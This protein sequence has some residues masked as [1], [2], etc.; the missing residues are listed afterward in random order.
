MDTYEKKYK[1][2]LER[3]KGVIEQNPLMEYLKKGIEYIFPELKESEDERIRKAIYNCVKWFGFDSSFFKYVSQ[4]ECL[5]WL[6]KQGEQN[7]AFE[8]KTPEESLGIDSDTYNKIV[9]EC[10]YGNHKPADKV[11]PKFKVGD[12]IVREL[13]N[14]CYQIKKC[15]LNVTNNK[16]GYDL[17]SGGYISSQD[18][19]FYHLWTISDAKAGD[20]LVSGDV[21]FILNKIHGVWVNCLCSL[22]KDG[23]FNNEDY[24][25]MH[26]KY[27]K[28]VYPA[29][30]EQRDTL[31]KAMA[32]S[33][34]AFDFEKKELK[35]IEQKFT[36]KYK[37]GDCIEYRGGKYKITKVT[38]TPHNFFYDVS[39]IEVHSDSEEVVI[40]IGMAA[41][42]QMFKIEQKP[43]WSEEDENIKQWIIS[44]IKKLLDLGKKSSII[45]DKEFEWIKSLKDRYTWK[46]SDEQMRTLEHYMHTLICNEHKEVL[47]GLYA[48]LKKLKEE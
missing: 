16:Y 27:S 25:L 37:N 39:L 22:H 8:M 47:F 15:I 4:E 5:A 48:D 46:P 30:K 45:A 42:E 10:I 1:E 29:T 14:T 36:P 21:I 3:A 9:D 18:A 44:D 43:A 24:D 13:D 38:V 31:E 19:N 23:S 40:S 17:T 6:E 26:I 20:V 32:D 12:W 35:K 2:A 33:G 7:P 11:E 34:W 41:E 28:E